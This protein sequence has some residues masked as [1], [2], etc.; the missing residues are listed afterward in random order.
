MAEEVVKELSRAGKHRGVA[1]ASITRLEGYID[2][3]EAKL[4]LS[5]TNLLM[6]PRLINKL[7]ELGA[8]I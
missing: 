5:K 2:K 8:D 3:L 1:C 7:E 6:I 4:E